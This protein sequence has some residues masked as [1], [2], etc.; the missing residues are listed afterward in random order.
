MNMRFC[1]W[2]CGIRGKNIFHFIGRE[3]ICAFIDRNPVLQ[4]TDYEGVPIISFGRYLKDYRD[5]IIIVSM[6]YEHEA[7]LGMLEQENL[8]VLSAHFLPPEI[9][10]AT[11]PEIFDI[12]DQKIG[13]GPLFLY[14][15]NLYSILL[16]KHYNQQ[17]VVRIIPEK[18]PPDW[19]RRKVETDFPGSLSSWEKVGSNTLYITNNEYS[20][21]NIP[22]DRK[23]ELF[24]FMYDIAAYHNPQIEKFKGIH[25]GRRCFIV[26]TG[27]SLRIEDLDRLKENGDLCI[28]MNGIFLLY[29]DTEWRPDYY[30]LEDSTGWKGW[31]DALMGGYGVKHMLIADACLKDI[32][33][34][35]CL[36][37][38]LSYLKVS[39]NCLPRFSTDFS[40]GAYAS[41]TVTYACLQFAFYL[42]CTE[43]YLYGLDHNYTAQHT[44]FTDHYLETTATDE[45]M[46]DYRCMQFAY[47][48]A[49]RKAKESG[50]RI[51]NTSRS[52]RL[53]LFERVD[54]DQVVP[55]KQNKRNL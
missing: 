38:H 12:I 40:H 5:G 46:D 24:D 41:G 35:E 2:G 7:V 53:G 3:H 32:S 26:A 22:V 34:P 16:L 37:F 29:D 6:Y 39:Q 30:L 31:K 23:A 4:G 20:N 42:G 18:K 49:Y 21:H 55:R 45:Y 8:E 48:S 52:T 11:C 36:R 1:I 47:E 33:P 43:I 19:L 14:G 50:V 54:F 10:E 25:A 28:S 15:L 44:H 13:D 27:P 9:L 51:Y 17:R